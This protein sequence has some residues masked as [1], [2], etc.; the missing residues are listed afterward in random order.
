[1]NLRRKQVKF[2]VLAIVGVGLAIHLSVSSIIGSQSK[3][4][5]VVNSGIEEKELESAS[6]VFVI[7]SR[8]VAEGDAE[9]VELSPRMACTI[10]SAARAGIDRNV[11]LFF[12]SQGRL[13]KLEDSTLINAL[14]SYSNVFFHSAN[15][16]KLS[17]GSP[18]EDFLKTDK[19][20]SSK[21]P[22]EHISDAARLVILWKYGG[23]YLDADVIVQRS[24]DSVPSNFICRQGTFFGNSVIAF[25]PEIKSRKLIEVFMEEFANS[26]DATEFAANGPELMTRVFKQVCGKENLDEIM[27]MK[28]CGSFHF[29]KD[30]ACYAIEWQ[31][32]KK[33]MSE[34]PAVAEEVMNQVSKSLVVHFW[35]Y[36]SK[37]HRLGTQSIA[38]YTQL[39]R[40][41]CPK[42]MEATSGDFF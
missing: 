3:M 18:M 24:F 6:N 32:W 25:S 8:T 15:I 37:G 20:K 27:E 41:Y 10:E 30:E 13:D 42:V 11:I 14:L 21:Y 17:I 36:L 5:K 40:K 23:V 34:D 28:D 2:L 31:Q 12:T 38:P 9:K 7:D 26:Y 1:M 29:L 16:T 4:R 33:L 35:N 19:L 22:L 39:A